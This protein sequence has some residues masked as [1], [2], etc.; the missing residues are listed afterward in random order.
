MTPGMNE[1][2]QPMFLDVPTLLE[3]SQ[4]RPSTVRLWQAGGV[5]VLVVIVS[6]Y[7]SGRNSQAAQVMS[8]LSALL[9]VLLIGAMGLISWFMFKAAKTEQAFIES[10]EELIRLRRWPEAGIMLEQMLAQPSRTQQARIQALIY[11]TAVLARYNRF[12]DAI[13]VQNYLLEN[14]PLDGG[15]AHGLRLA[16]AMAMLREDHLFDADRAINELRRQVTRAG[17]A[18]NEANI[19]ADD[20]NTADA[21]EAARPETPEQAPQSLSAGLALI[22]IYRDVKTGHPTEAIELFDAS[23]SSLREQLGHRVADAHVLVARAYD[24]L[25]RDAE[26]RSHYEKATL[27]AP[28]AE[29]HRRYPETTILASKYPPAAAPKEAA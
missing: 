2:M 14:A 19:Q 6:A 29:L 11:L 13:A 10:I 12:D 16:R 27:L 25:A 21:A 8:V 3:Q 20:A 24:L 1:P 28:P 7:I 23:L 17:R 18:F 26:A 5:F 22:E 9:M 4:P 15:T